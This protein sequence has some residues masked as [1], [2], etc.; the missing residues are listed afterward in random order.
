[1]PEN[2]NIKDLV[3]KHEREISQLTAIQEILIKQINKIG[4]AVETISAAIVEIKATIKQQNK[5]LKMALDTKKELL[6]INK[7]L[8]LERE[9]QKDINQ[10]LFERIERLEKDVK[11]IKKEV[12]AI[13]E[14]TQFA[15]WL[16]GGFKTLSKRAA[17]FILLALA[18]IVLGAFLGIDL[19]HLLRK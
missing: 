14:S 10:R 17:A 19:H 18:L 2:D 8:L 1:M 3:L 6:E 13:S 11:D 15:R 5:E 12:E 7:T 16:D 4:E 9:Q